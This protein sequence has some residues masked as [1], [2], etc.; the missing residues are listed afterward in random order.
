MGLTKPQWNNSLS[1]PAEISIHPVQIKS[2]GS[3][4]MKSQ[5]LH[6]EVFITDP[7]AT[8]DGKFFIIIRTP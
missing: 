4:I 2:A 7:I 3:K 8:A 1:F 6:N 5:S